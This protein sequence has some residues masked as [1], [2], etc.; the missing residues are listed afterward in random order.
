MW[1]RKKILSS[2]DFPKRKLMPGRK[3]SMSRGIGVVWD[4]EIETLYWKLMQRIVSDFFTFFIVKVI[5]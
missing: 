2:L 3:I 1:H 4:Y 5:A